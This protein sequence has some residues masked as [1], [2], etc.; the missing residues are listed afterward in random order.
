MDGI[1]LCF[2]INID[3]LD[4]DDDD[5]CCDQQVAEEDEDELEQQLQAV[6]LELETIRKDRRLASQQHKLDCKQRDMEFHRCKG[7]IHKLVKRGHDAKLYNHALQTVFG[8]NMPQQYVL[9]RQ[10]MLLQMLHKTDICLNQIKV[11]QQ[12][13][14]KTVN[15]MM[16]EAS[17]IETEQKDLEKELMMK[18]GEFMNQKL[19]M[20]HEFH[21]ESTSQRNS[22]RKLKDEL[23]IPE[24][25]P[26]KFDEISVGTTDTAPLEDGSPISPLAIREIKR[27]ISKMWG[28]SY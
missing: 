24:V 25:D 27:S 5:V 17:V 18:Q 6:R 20:E 2:D 7:K 4:S 1:D 21:C 3:D 12:H 13:S 19:E 10:A 23:D 22:I 16:V 15:Y 8:K 11:I 9:Q 26:K 14:N 28:L